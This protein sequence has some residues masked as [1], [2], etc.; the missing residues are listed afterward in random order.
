MSSA[1]TSSLW[2]T[3][4][5]RAAAVRE[6]HHWAGCSSF[7]Y[8]YVVPLCGLIFCLVY[9]PLLKFRTACIIL[10]LF[11]SANSVVC[12]CMNPPSSQRFTCYSNP[13]RFVVNQGPAGFLTDSGLFR[14]RREMTLILRDLDNRI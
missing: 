11:A 7:V 4:E 9:F 8:S 10:S 1:V 6:K 5:R 13:V 12:G 2:I 3:L 14:F